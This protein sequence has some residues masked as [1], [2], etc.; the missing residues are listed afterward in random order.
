MP[1]SPRGSISQ[2]LGDWMQLLHVFRDDLDDDD[3]RDRSRRRRK[4]QESPSAAKILIGIGICIAAVVLFVAG[5]FI[6]VWA[7]RKKEAS[8][9]SAGLRIANAGLLTMGMKVP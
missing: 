9:M 2:K 1:L 7:V 8:I 4:E 3:D 5:I 6:L